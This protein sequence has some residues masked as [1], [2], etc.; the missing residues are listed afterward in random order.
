MPIP[1]SREQLKQYALRALGKPVIEINV[2]D[3]QLEDRIDEALQYFAQYHFDGVRR[4]YLKYQYTQAD[5]DRMTVDRVSQSTTKEA[6]EVKN[7]FVGDGSTKVFTLDTSADELNSVKVNIK[8][9]DDILN[10]FTG[11]GSTKVFQ[12]T[13]PADN[14]DALTVT[15]D[16]ILLTRT[17]D[18]IVALKTFEFI[19]APTA[20][21]VIE[22]KIRNTIPAGGLDL[23]AGLGYTVADK[24]LTFFTAPASNANISVTINNKVTTEWKEA[25]NYIICP[26]SVVSVINI[27]PFSSKG[28]MNIF[29]VRYQMRLNDLYNFS[30]GSIVNYDMVMRQLDFLDHILVGEKPMR[31]NQHDNRLYVDMDWKNDLLVGE[32]LVIECYRKL[33]PSQHTDVF[34][35]IMLKRYVT[36]LFKKQ[37]GAN[38]SKFS[39]VA[40]LGGVTLNGQ[41]IFSE[42]L[43][44][45]QDLEKEIRS[46][47]EMSQPLMIG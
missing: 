44:D 12:L 22:V 20:G 47:F 41:Q 37:W 40:M 25:Q 42:S 16:G 26:E 2:D 13:N 4:T 10:T 34:N 19:T 28:S 33:D 35:D 45:I 38:L 5:Y 36:A 9:D 39:G 8:E 46:S 17:T 3:D 1:S 29:D 7:S 30:S 43:T 11:D 15:V 18:F 24:T 27:F 31:F 14:V 6:S 32:Y 23:V 21:Q